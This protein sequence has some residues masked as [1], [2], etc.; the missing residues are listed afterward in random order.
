[1]AVPATEAATVPESAAW[2]SQPDMAYVAVVGTVTS[3][4]IRCPG[5]PAVRNAW[6]PPD[7]C[8][9]NP[10]MSCTPSTSSGAFIPHSASASTPVPVATVASAEGAPTFPTGSTGTTV[11]YIV[12][13]NGA[14]RSA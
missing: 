2:V 9:P 13:P 14:A 7:H 10:V 1:M 11:Y 5:P 12:V 6:A 3:K 8:G 4:S